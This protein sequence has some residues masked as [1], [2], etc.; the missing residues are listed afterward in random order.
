MPP[1]YVCT[2]SIRVDQKG[3][4]LTNASQDYISGLMTKLKIYKNPQTGSVENENLDASVFYSFIEPP[5]DDEDNDVH[6]ATAKTENRQIELLDSH[7]S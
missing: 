7:C 6:L 5:S 3:E 2:Y 1:G 4:S